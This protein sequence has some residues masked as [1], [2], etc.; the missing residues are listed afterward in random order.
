MFYKPF[1]PIFFYTLSWIDVLNYDLF[2]EGT[3][4]IISKR[5]WL[6]S[7]QKV[8]QH[9]EIIKLN[10]VIT[11]LSKIKLFKFILVLVSLFFGFPLVKTYNKILQKDYNQFFY[12]EFWGGYKQQWQ[13]RI[14]WSYFS[15]AYFYPWFN[16]RGS[17][18]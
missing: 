11:I 5:R 15:C 2:R 12:R 7:R 9:L 18:T 4:M 13:P 3:I 1:L 14:R 17:N 10:K 8:F 6:S 16:W